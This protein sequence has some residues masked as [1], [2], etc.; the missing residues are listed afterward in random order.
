MST[1]ELLEWRD[2]HYQHVTYLKSSEI[3]AKE[4]MRKLNEGYTG[5]RYV[6]RCKSEAKEG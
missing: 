2:R 3:E 6:I 5:E 4:A 1:Y